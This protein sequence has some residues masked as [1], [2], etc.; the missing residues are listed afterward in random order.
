MR[1]ERIKENTKTGLCPDSLV[2]VKQMGNITEIRYMLKRTGGFICKLDKESYYDI[3]TGE[4]KAFNKSAAR[5]ENKESVSRSL[6][7]LRDIINTNVTDIG[8]VL[9]VTLTYKENMTDNVRLYNDYRKFNMRFREYRQRKNLPMCE[10]IATAEPQGRGAWHLHILYIF[11]AKAP[12]IK[13][14]ALADLWGH[15]FVSITSL[16]GIDNIGVY[17]TAYLSN[18][19]ITAELSEDNRHK[20]A[21]IKGARIR[22]YPTGFRIYRC[23]RGIRKP[24]IYETTEGAAM[25]EVKGAV[26]TYEKTIQLSDDDGRMIN[27][28]NY[29]HFNQKKRGKR[30]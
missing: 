18:L 30:L 1:I 6:K 10:Y 14:K 5:I 26:L 4:V 29:R 22:L 16:K 8:K 20:K 24:K 28:I 9:W 27:R 25:R 23:S 3:R 2:T 13:N 11:P 15:G 12:F 7:N 17:L 21:I 19:D